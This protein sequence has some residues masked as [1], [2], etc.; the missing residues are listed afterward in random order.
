LLTIWFIV[1][2]ALAISLAFAAGQIRRAPLSTGIVYLGA[3]YLLGANVFG[4]IDLDPAA[5]WRIIEWITSIVIVVSIFSGALKMRVPLLDRRWLDPIRLAFLAMA[6]GTCGA[7]AVAYWILR[8]PIGASLILAAILAPTDPVL[9]SDVQVERPF[10]FHRLR[11]ALTGEAGMNDGAALPLVTLGLTLLG[12]APSSTPARW[13][14]LHVAWGVLGGIA[15]GGTL[16]YLAARYMLHLRLVH[17]EKTGT[18]NFLALGVMGLSYGLASVA[19]AIGFLAVFAAGVAVRGIE[20]RMDEQPPEVIELQINQP[21]GEQEAA[22]DA[23]KAAAFMLLRLQSYTENLERMGEAAVVVLVGSLLRRAMFG[24][25]TLIF[26]A[27]LL[28]VVRPFSVYTTT[29]GSR[30]GWAGRT[31]AAWFGIRGLASIYYLAYLRSQGAPAPLV[32][33]LAEIA[34]GVV[35]CS[36]VLHGVSVTPLMRWFDNRRKAED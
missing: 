8:L 2:G 7:V 13:V 25:Q 35:T 23:D 10:E 26:A 21:S 24:T 12:V 18:D 15:I 30:M 32:H 20:Q 27:L 29:L 11:F 9:A 31:M 3:G 33:K 5:H 14:L 17:K 4:L 28:F 34:V 1:A 16:G 6:V 22:T 36:I 19:H